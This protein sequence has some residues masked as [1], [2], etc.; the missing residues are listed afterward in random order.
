MLLAVTGTPGTGKTAVCE[1]LS[2]KGYSILN[3]GKIIRDERLFNGFDDESSAY[4][5]DT[6]VLLKY[7]E[8]KH[9]GEEADRWTIV[10]S[11][12]SHV[13]NVSGIVLLRCNPHELERRLLERDYKNEKIRTNVESELVDVIGMEVISQKLPS[14]EIDNTEKDAEHTAAE[15]IEFIRSFPDTAG[16]SEPCTVNWIGDI[17]GGK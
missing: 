13:L 12:L 11:H 16:F 14:I 3:L 9:I 17:Y 8:E 4:E 5:V 2:D 10:D 15:I 1:R 6:D 7:F